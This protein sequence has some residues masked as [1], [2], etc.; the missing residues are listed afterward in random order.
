MAYGFVALAVWRH[1]PL[2]IRSCDR[3]IIGRALVGHFLSQVE[4]GEQLSQCCQLYLF[5]AHF[6]NLDLSPS[7]TTVPLAVKQVLSREF[8]LWS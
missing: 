3:F 4:V 5:P 1:V 8:G 7:L 6:S 2:I